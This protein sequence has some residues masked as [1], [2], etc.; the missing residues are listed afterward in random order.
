MFRMIAIGLLLMLASC[1]RAPGEDTV[2]SLVT[3]PDRLR[4]VE[5]Q[6]SDNY[7]KM[8]AAE[9]NVASIARHRLFMDNGKSAY[10]PSKK[11]SKF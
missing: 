6:C 8:G 1:G 7:T 11:Q 5:Q 9:C 4:Q 3:H 2:E 10:T